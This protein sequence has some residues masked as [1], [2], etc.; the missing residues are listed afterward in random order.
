[1][2]EGRKRSAVVAFGSLGEVSAVL[3]MPIWY[4]DNDSHCYWLQS[5]NPANIKVMKDPQAD[6]RR[7]PVMFSPNVVSVHI[8]CVLLTHPKD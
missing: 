3:H 1:M 4:F 2:S 5:C 6:W 8:L 7:H